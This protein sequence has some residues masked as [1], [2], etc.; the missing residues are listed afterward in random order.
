MTSK[1]DLFSSN[2]SHLMQ[3]IYDLIKS[4]LFYLKPIYI[5]NVSYHLFIDASIIYLPMDIVYT[6]YTCSKDDEVNAE[7]LAT[8]ETPCASHPMHKMWATFCRQVTTRLRCSSQLPWLQKS[9]MVEYAGVTGIIG[10]M[11]W[12]HRISGVAFKLFHFH[13]GWNSHCV[14]K[15]TFPPQVDGE[16]FNRKSLDVG[17]GRISSWV[18]GT[19]VEIASCLSVICIRCAC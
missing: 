11:A 1:F 10:S 6:V 3:S 13:Q 7:T 5:V 17:S 14:T 8:G 4:Y 2:I 12:L 15:L 19:M 18:I 9:E 16:K